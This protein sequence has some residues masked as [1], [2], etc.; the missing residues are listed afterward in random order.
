MDSA[1]TPSLTLS[2]GP[3][4]VLGENLIVIGKNSYI[5]GYIANEA[6]RYGAQVEA[7]GS[8]DCDFLDGDAVTRFF[9]SLPARPCSVVFL[10][11]INKTVDNTFE[12]LQRNLSLVR[13]FAGAQAAA[14]IKSV[15]YFS[16]VDVY[17]RAPKLPLTE[18]SPIRPDSWYGLAKF[19]CEWILSES[20]M[21]QAPVTVLRIPGV[22]GPAKNDRSVIGQIVESVRSRRTFTIHGSG[23]ARRD[24]VH[25][26]DVF[27][28]VRS[29]ITSSH[30]GTVNVATGQSYSIA[31][32]A[33]FVADELG[34]YLEIA[35]EGAFEERDFDLEFDNSRIQT[36]SPGFVFKDI[37]HAIATY[38]N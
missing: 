24:Y 33:R 19:G 12:S 23:N 6:T 17:G 25:V 30:R 9:T 36:L 32:I 22:F 10:A 38:R 13:N 29:A 7:V 11:V 37:R 15:V 28:L 16:S 8:E 2:P 3:R 35:H 5:G 18:N 27:Q 34:E 14:K 26:D 21:V 20:G 1:L 4:A 31:E